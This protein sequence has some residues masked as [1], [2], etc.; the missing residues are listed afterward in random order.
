[1]VKPKG[2]EGEAIRS[3]V[4]LLQEVA[5]FINKVA[6]YSRGIFAGLVAHVAAVK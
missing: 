2:I 6:G 1:M 3:R 5:K 4:L